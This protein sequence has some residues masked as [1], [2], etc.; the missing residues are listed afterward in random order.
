LGRS[1]NTVLTAAA[2]MSSVPNTK[3]RIISSR[4]ALWPIVE[5]IFALSEFGVNSARYLTR[6]SFGAVRSIVSRRVLASTFA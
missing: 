5:A 6:R 3:P 4:S 2:R 1:Q